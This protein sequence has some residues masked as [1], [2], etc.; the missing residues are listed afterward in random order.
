MVEDIGTSFNIHAYKDEANSKTTLIEGLVS[1]SQNG[2]NKILKP[3]QQAQIYK[4]FNNNNNN[5]ISIIN[6]VDLEETLAWKN[7]YFKFNGS[8]IE[9]VMKQVERWYNV[10]FIYKDKISD[11]FVAKIKRDV[12][13]SE[14][15]ELLEGTGLVHFEINGNKITVKK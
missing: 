2:T 4:S 14:I 6:N 11:D 1:I 12:P 10:E 13:V 7:G 8:S 9:E 15:L 5:T 3:G